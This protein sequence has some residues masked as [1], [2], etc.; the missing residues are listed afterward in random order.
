MDEILSHAAIFQASVNQHCLNQ[1]VTRNKG[2]VADAA[3]LKAKMMSLQKQ[4]K[5]DVITVDV[6][7]FYYPKNGTAAK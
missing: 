1:P 3:C 5:A 7:L 2:L 6:S 4:A